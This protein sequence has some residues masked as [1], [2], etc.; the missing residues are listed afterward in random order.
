MTRKTWHMLAGAAVG[1]AILIGLGVWQLERLAWKEALIANMGARGAAAIRDEQVVGVIATGQEDADQRL[2]VRGPS[3]GS[4]RAGELQLGE[5]VH[6]A[7]D[8]QA[9]AGALHEEV[10]AVGLA[11]IRGLAKEDIHKDVCLNVS[12]DADRGS[13][14][15][16]GCG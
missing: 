1:C 15:G 10:T 3:R 14:T 5:R 6:H 12:N 8:A 4:R 9:G 13:M 11:A 7:G 2:D 16:R